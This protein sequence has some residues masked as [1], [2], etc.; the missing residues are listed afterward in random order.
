M[1]GIWWEYG[2]HA[3]YETEWVDIWVTLAECLFFNV[4]FSN[5]E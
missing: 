1:G 5:V 4:M 2:D 3:I